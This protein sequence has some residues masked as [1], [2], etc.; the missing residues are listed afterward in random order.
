MSRVRL[1][2]NGVAAAIIMEAVMAGLSRVAGAVKWS[3]PVNWIQLPKSGDFINLGHIARVQL[4]GE[5]RTVV[6]M[7]N[8]SEFTYE[9]EDGQALRTAL[10][11]VVPDDPGSW[12]FR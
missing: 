7:C 6:S 8:G 11:T 12:A 9:G 2:G 1:L 10:A 3:T 5:D 4:V